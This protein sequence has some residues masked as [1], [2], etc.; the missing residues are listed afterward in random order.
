MPEQDPPPGPDD[1]QSIAAC[2]RILDVARGH[3][4]TARHEAGRGWNADAV[5]DELLAALE[6][7]AAAITR[8]GAPIPR[9]LRAEID[10]YRRL[11]NRP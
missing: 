7:Y 2:L 9:T 1:R 6:G 4:R 5:R 8:V 10:L 3:L 11:R